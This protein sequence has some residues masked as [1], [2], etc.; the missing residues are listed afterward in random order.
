[1]V[2][3][4]KEVERIA[5]LARIDIDDPDKERFITEFNAVLNYM[6]KI[7]TLLMNEQLEKVNHSSENRWRSDQVQPSLSREIALKNAPDTHHHF[8]SVPRVI[9]K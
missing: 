5:R 3:S 4:N 1:M 9:K 8:I 2:I 7:N 6:E